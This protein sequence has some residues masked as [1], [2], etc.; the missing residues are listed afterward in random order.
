MSHLR[1]C[2]LLLGLCV[3]C[4]IID[5]PTP[6]PTATPRPTAIPNTPT[7]V[8]CPYPAEPIILTLFEPIADDI[9]VKVITPQKDFPLVAYLDPE[10][11]GQSYTFDNPQS[12]EQRIVIDNLP[13]NENM[14]VENGIIAYDDTP[15]RAQLRQG[16]QTHERQEVNVTSMTLEFDIEEDEL[17]CALADFREDRV[18]VRQTTAV[19]GEETSASLQAS[20]LMTDLS[21]SNCQIAPVLT[22]VDFDITLPAGTHMDETH[23]VYWAG[24]EAVSE[25]DCDWVNGRYLC[26]TA[27]GI[28]LIGQPFFVG[29][30]TGPSIHQPTDAKIAFSLPLNN[31]CVIFTP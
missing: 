7:P 2:L 1:I 19:I 25:A 11:D 30:L 28:P 23:V 31:M 26:T 27:V 10:F 8:G 20:L 13:L 15:F 18:R 3:G 16:Q 9:R 5:T 4:T 14:R 29:I 22:E 12:G 24:E 21:A 17:G 6:I